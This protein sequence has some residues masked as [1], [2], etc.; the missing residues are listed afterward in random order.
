MHY[1]SIVLCEKYTEFIKYKCPLEKKNQ[2]RISKI[3]FVV[4]ESAAH[5]KIR[6]VVFDSGWIKQNQAGTG[7]PF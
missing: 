4:K 7:E 6:P 1:I 2:Y 5:F 3:Y